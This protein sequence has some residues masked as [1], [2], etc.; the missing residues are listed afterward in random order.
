MPPVI[1]LD[2]CITGDVATYCYFATVY[3]L[4]LIVFLFVITCIVVQSLTV[5]HRVAKIIKDM[6]KLHNEHKA[7]RH[8]RSQLM[9][10]TG[11]LH[12]G[13]HDFTIN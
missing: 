2:S 13:D 9:A 4:V 8:L 12:T 6:W 1:R 10:Q 3:Q 7:E 11:A 5:R